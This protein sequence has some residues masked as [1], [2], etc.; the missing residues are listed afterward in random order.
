MV[1]R[2]SGVVFEREDTRVKI[3]YVD[4]D[5]LALKESFDLAHA[6]QRAVF[7]RLF[8]RRFQ[9]AV[10]PVQFSSAQEVVTLSEGFSAPD[11]VIARKVGKHWRVKE[12]LFDY[13]GAYRKANEL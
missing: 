9:H 10:K 11:F 5:G 6:G 3:S 1:I 7:N 8:G 12:R 4:E 13:V 2:C